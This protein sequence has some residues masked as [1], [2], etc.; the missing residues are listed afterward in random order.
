MADSSLEE[1]IAAGLNGF[2]SGLEA[3]LSMVRIAAE[4]NKDSA[5]ISL[6]KVANIMQQVLDEFIQDHTNE[7]KR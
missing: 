4:R 3:G 7:I 6:D 5:D 1:V 2:I